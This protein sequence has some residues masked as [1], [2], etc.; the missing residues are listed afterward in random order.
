MEIV[1]SI[2]WFLNQDTLNYICDLMCEDR[3]R[4][5]DVKDICTFTE[6]FNIE[7]QKLNFPYDLIVSFEETGWEQ[8]LGDFNIKCSVHPFPFETLNILSIIIQLPK[9]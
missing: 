2:G 5:I 4:I 9:N 8:I 3:I 1:N 6:K 7:N